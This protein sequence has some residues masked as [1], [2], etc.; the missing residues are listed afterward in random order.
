MSLLFL[1]T[2]GGVR[3]VG[4]TK[5]HFS[6]R[7][8]VEPQSLRRG[9]YSSMAPTGHQYDFDLLVIGGGSAGLAASKVLNKECVEIWEKCIDFYLF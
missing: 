1:K 7:C 5:T 9:R 6:S 8:A 2:E 4:V 3:G